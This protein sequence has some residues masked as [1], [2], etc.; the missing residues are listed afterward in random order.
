MNDLPDF[1]TGQIG[2]KQ[3]SKPIALQ[4]VENVPKIT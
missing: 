3:A 4:V 1:V 2:P